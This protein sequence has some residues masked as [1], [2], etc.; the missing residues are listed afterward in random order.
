[1]IAA[2]SGKILRK[3]GDRVIVDVSGVGYEVFISTD[4]LARLPDKGEEVFLHIHTYVREDTLVLFGFLEDQEKELFLVLKTVAGIGPKLALAMLSGMPLGELCRAIAE[5][6]NKRLTTL[7]GV[8]KKTAERI[9]VEL[10]DK[11]GTLAAETTSGGIKH[12][13]VSQPGSAVYDTLSAL[14]NLGYP[15]PVARETLAAVKKRLGGEAFNLLRVEEM[16]REALRALA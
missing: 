14:T 2:L 9:C 13:T 6:D 5:G 15:D 7:P 12:A 11:V 1:M 8:G 16:I 10:R 4:A 3:T